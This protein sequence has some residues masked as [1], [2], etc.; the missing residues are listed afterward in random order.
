[1]L[2]KDDDVETAS[3][4]LRRLQSMKFFIENNY[5]PLHAAAITGALIGV[6]SLITYQENETRIGIA[7][8]ERTSV[9]GSRYNGLLRFAATQQP[10][11]DWKLYSTQLK[12]VLFELNNRF[13]QT[14]SKLL[15]ATDIKEASKIVNREYLFTTAETTQFAELAYD[16]VF[17]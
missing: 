5:S 1:M 10:S 13:N 12:Y 11:V 3:L 17:V 4:G 9:V 2:F 7:S 15:A 6:S 14:N 8:W 16:E